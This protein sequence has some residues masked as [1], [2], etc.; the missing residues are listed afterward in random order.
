[1][2]NRD[3][4]GM[5]S[6]SL[7]I[8]IAVFGVCIVVVVGVFALCGFQYMNAGLSG[9][10][11]SDKEMAS[12]KDLSESS[13]VDGGKT[14][15]QGTKASTEAFSEAITD[16]SSEGS[17]EAENE[18]ESTVAVIDE[19]DPSDFVFVDSDSRYLKEEDLQLIVED[20]FASGEDA[21]FQLSIARNEIYARHGFVFKTNLKAKE[22]F[23]KMDWYNPSDLTQEEIYEQFNDYE[24]KNVDFIAKYEKE[25]GYR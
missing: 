7:T 23:E 5:K 18:W 15:S 13:T 8:V 11:L 2:K 1:M 14:T 4:Q 9:K 20:T 10:G 12:G 19:F 16:A 21:G 25:H 6:K 3:D 22:H 24:K 17:T